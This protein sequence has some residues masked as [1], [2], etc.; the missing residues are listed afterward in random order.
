[1]DKRLSREI[2]NLLYFRVPIGISNL[3]HGEWKILIVF[4]KVEM[5]IF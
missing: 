4:S 3:K 5:T 1:M 2:P